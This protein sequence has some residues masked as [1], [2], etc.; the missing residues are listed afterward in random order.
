MSNLAAYGYTYDFVTK[1][2]A[3]DLFRVRPAAYR[4]T[5]TVAG[6]AGLHR[7]LRHP[8][9]SMDLKNVTGRPRMA[10]RLVMPCG[11]VVE[12]LLEAYPE[13]LDREYG[14]S[15]TATKAVFQRL[16]KPE[17]GP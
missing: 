14:T 6:L 5:V 12:A 8:G 17:S 11:R 2:S 3:E 15:A 1:K 9:R 7:C 4:R 10:M 13:S 16:S